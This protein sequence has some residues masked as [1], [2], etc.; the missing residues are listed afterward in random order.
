MSDALANFSA[1]VVRVESRSA[2]FA[3]IEEH[4]PCD[5]PGE[6][7]RPERWRWSFSSPPR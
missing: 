5:E 1:E 3:S 6:K 7:E 2:P 4:Q